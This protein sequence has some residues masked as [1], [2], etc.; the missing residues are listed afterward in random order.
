M[1]SL[2][3]LPTTLR[4]AP[5]H[6][7]ALSRDESQDSST[8][9]IGEGSGSSGLRDGLTLPAEGQLDAPTWT[10]PA[11]CPRGTEQPRLAPARSRSD[12]R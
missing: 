10:T 11:E 6:D 2:C 8:G 4:P 1:A 3:L 12:F 9:D 5:N 7:A